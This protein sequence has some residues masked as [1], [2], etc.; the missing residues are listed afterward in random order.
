MRKPAKVVIVSQHFAPDPSTTATYVTAIAKGLTDDL[1]VLAI[2]GTANSRTGISDAGSLRVIEL[3]NWMPRKDALFRRAI[4]VLFFAVQ[5]FV[6]TLRHARKHDLV[7]CVTNPFTLPYAATFAARLRGSASILLIYDL[8]PEA[9]EMAGLV[10]STSVVAKAIRFANGIL[11]RTLDTIITIGRDVE[12]LLL[13]YAGVERSKIEFISN[14]NLLPIR[15]REFTPANSIRA[16]YPGKF[17]VGLSGNLGFTH[18]PET[19]FEAAKLLQNRTEI[20]FLLSGW[21][22]GWQKLEKLQAVTRLQ[23]VTLMPPVDEVALEDFLT[24]ANIWIIPYR[25]NV[26]G[27]SVPSRLYNLLAIGRPV[28]VCAE[29]TSEAARIVDEEAIGWAV[30]PEDPDAL[31]AAIQAAATNPDDTIL[32]GKRSAV[33]A[34][35]YT[36]EASMSRYR[37]VVGDILKHRAR[38]Q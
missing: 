4:A 3:R 24:S 25:R 37:Q 12:P 30:A 33:A 18:S 10:R 19:V 27:V 26:A 14:W 9:L 29:S 22:S 36:Y 28:V 1:Q 38:R 35:K 2:S 11:F 23:N 31:A 6:A 13:Q 7:F 15:Y 20:H 16:K 17:I 21:G 5:T 8:Y 34:H 32:K